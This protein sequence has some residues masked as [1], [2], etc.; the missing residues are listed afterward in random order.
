MPDQFTGSTDRDVLE[1]IAN[2][3]A[4]M[5][6]QFDYLERDTRERAVR[7]DEDRTEL[8]AVKS[9][10]DG[11]W[12]IVGEEEN[13]G[14]RG[15]VRMLVRFAYGCSGAFVLFEVLSKTGVIKF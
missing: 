5:S 8:A 3:V 2:Q 1:R 4:K 7:C 12:K 14:M 6:A 15:D 9:R 10:C 13:K 11:V